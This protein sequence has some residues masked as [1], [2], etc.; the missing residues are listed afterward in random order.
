VLIFG[1][2]AIRS[3]ESKPASVTAPIT[4]ADVA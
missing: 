4:D 1:R 3:Q 2:S